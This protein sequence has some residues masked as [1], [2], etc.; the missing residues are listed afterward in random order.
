[1]ET[2]KI[3]E[4][5]KNNKCENFYFNGLKERTLKQKYQ[6]LKN[7]FE[8]DILNSWNQLKTIANN[9][10]VYNMGLTNEQQNNFFL[11]NEI[12]N[13]FLYYETISIIKEFEQLTKTKIYFNG[14][15]GRIYCTC[16]RF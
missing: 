15:S 16:T 6:Y 4:Y 7:H 5:I 10:K 2:K 1:M 13:N 12:D 11:I 8:Y 14:R 3:K 9:V